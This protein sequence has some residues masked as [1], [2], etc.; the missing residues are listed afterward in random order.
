MNVLKCFEILKKI[1][2]FN[3]FILFEEIL[4]TEFLF[5]TIFDVC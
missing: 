2:Y 5:S 1:K 4:P 3:L